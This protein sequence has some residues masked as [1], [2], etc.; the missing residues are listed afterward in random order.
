MITGFF[1]TVMVDLV[2][3]LVT[4]AFATA[5]RRRVGSQHA[6]K[7]FKT[8]S[9]SLE[10]VPVAPTPPPSSAG[11]KFATVAPAK[12]PTE[13]ARGDLAQSIFKLVRNGITNRSGRKPLQ[14]YLDARS[15]TVA[16]PPELYEK[17][18]QCAVRIGRAE[19]VPQILDD[20]VRDEVPRSLALYEGAMKQLA[21][22]KQ[23][24]LALDLYD[25]LV[26]D[27]L[28]PSNDTMAC[29]VSFASQVGDLDRAMDLFAKLSSMTTPSIRAYMT[30]LRV[31]AQ[32]KDWDT[33]LLTFRDMECRLAS[34]DSLALNVTLGTG[35][36]TDNFDGVVALF[37]DIVARKPALPDVVSYNTV[38]KGYAQGGDATRALALLDKMLD[39]ALP[40]VTPNAITFNTVMD[41]VM[42]SSMP[43]KAWD[44]LDSAQASGFKPDQVTCTIMIKGMAKASCTSD[45]VTRCTRLLREHGSTCDGTLRAVLYN[46]MLEMAHPYDIDLCLDLFDEMRQR[47]IEV[48]P[49]MQNL[50]LSALQ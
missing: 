3:F 14:L 15:E 13:V 41:A 20:M 49:T 1:D 32:R 48:K 37:N 44:V 43:L 5:M 16:G 26:A 10:A 46:A 45:H 31:H 21:S 35:V 2:L 29:L 8:Q 7:A 30:I 25:G 23:P 34:A 17:L 18:I 4:L 28:E 40:R 11:R 22:H 50:V 27:G 19:L 33:A 47:N 6:A 24:K 9:S 36:A 38:L 42:R 39:V 12:P